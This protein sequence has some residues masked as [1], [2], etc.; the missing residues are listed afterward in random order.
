[1]KQ[2]TLTFTSEESKERIHSILEELFWDGE[3]FDELQDVSWV[4]KE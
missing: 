3:H 1:M 2:V 4:I